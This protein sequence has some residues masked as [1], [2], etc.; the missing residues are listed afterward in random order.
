MWELTSWRRYLLI[1]AH[2]PV[3][4]RQSGWRC[5][6]CRYLLLLCSAG[7]VLITPSW[8]K[9]VSLVGTSTRAPPPVALARSS[10]KL[11][12]IRR[13]FSC[14]P[15]RPTD[16]RPLSATPDTWAEKFESFERI[17]AI[18]ET[19]GN[20]DSCNLCKRLGTS[21]LHELLESKFPFVSRIA[22]IRSKLANF[23]AHVSGVSAV[24]MDTPLLQWR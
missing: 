2:T 22:F 6:K 3:M 15:G 9:V 14:P 13:P 8:G 24:A 11:A 16:V 17:N 19:N 10:G 18:R 5:D 23:S 1:R 20:F 7:A 4:C 21:R 12:S